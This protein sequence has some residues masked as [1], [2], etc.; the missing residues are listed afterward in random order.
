MPFTNDTELVAQVKAFLHRGDD[1]T[2]DQVYDWIRL[3]ELAVNRKV[4]LRDAEAESAVAFTSGDP[5]YTFPATW[6]GIRS[7]AIAQQG[8]FK[9]LKMIS[10]QNAETQKLWTADAG[11][12]TYCYIN[13]QNIHV[14]PTVKSDTDAKILHVGADIDLRTTNTNWLLQQ[15]PDC[16]LYGALTHSAGF[17]GE[18]E[19][20]QTWNAFFS[21]ALESVEKVLWDWKFMAVGG[22]ARPDIHVPSGKILQRQTR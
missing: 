6:K 17:I 19:R 10:A 8:F 4:D 9:N 12:P 21:D 7:V 14:I 16:Y 5:A 22:Q 13:G 20:I 1:I 15:A 2:D 11:D 3:T 18:D